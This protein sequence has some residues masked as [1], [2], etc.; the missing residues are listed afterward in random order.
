MKADVHGA[1]NMLSLEKS[2]SSLMQ[3]AVVCGERVH[4]LVISL[5]GSLRQE[6]FALETG[7]VCTVRIC[8]KN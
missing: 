4:T 1:V 8:L 6:D 7:L 2:V 5:L 3:V